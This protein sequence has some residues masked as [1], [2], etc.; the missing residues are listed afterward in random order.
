MHLIVK[1]FNLLSF[2]DKVM[3][4]FIEINDFFTNTVEV[5]IREISVHLNIILVLRM[6]LLQLLALA[7]SENLLSNRSCWVKVKQSN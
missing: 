2:Y 5:Y 7:E 1:I 4:A 6:Q 3:N